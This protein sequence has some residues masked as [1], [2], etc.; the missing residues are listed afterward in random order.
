MVDDELVNT[1][2][3][4]EILG[5]RPAFLQRD[6]VTSTNV[7]FIQVGNRAVRYSRNDL[8]KYISGRRQG[9]DLEPEGA[10]FDD[11]DSEYEELD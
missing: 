9:P 6:R 10:E 7:P 3:A 4:A 2:E 1:E 11:G 8:Q 5:V